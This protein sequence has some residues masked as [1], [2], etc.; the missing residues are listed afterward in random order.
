[1]TEVL[2][3][4]V[5][6]LG[7][8]TTYAT[9]SEADWKDAVRAVFT[10][11]GLGPWTARFSVRME[12]RLPES[13]TANK[14]WDLDNLIKPTLDAMEGVFGLCRWQ[15]RR[16]Q[17]TIRLTILRRASGLLALVSYKGLESKCGVSF[18]NSYDLSVWLPDRIP[19]DNFS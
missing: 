3:L 14:V 4:V 16:S 7:R 10:A 15:G 12:F 11:T 17:Q 18:P 1:M 2:L 9:K 19:L 5:D 6:V 8:P 13:R